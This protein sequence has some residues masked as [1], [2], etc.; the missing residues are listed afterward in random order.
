MHEPL[1]TDE[2]NNI[3]VGR[4]SDHPIKIPEALQEGI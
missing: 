1:H 2:H 4:S 3:T